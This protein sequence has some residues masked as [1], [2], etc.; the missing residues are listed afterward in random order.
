VMAWRARGAER[1][2]CSRSTSS[3]SRRTRSATGARWVEA[4]TRPSGGRESSVAPSRAGPTPTSTVPGPTVPCTGDAMRSVARAPAAPTRTTRT[5]TRQPR[6]SHRRGRR[7]MAPGC[8][9]DRH[10]RHHPAPAPE[11]GPGRPATRTRRRRT[12]PLR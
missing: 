6:G 11:R 5:A 4:T 3:S 10:P 7:G 8:R 9:T 2:R 1:V 12:G